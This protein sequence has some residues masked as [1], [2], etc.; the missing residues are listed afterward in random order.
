MIKLELS[1]RDVIL[2]VLTVAAIWAFIELWPV[3]LLVFVSFIFMIGLLPYVDALERSGIR[4]SLSVLIVIAG[5]LAIIL[6]AFS[7]MVPA[8]ID[9]VSAVRDN[10]PE[11]ARELE[12][13]FASFGINVELQERARNVN[14]EELISGRAA[15][16]Y[17]QRVLTTTL[18]IITIA[19]MT[20]YLLADT[21][22]LAR[23]IAQFIPGDRLPEAES[24]FLSISRVVGGYLRGQLI[25]S[26]A[27]AVFTF[28]LLQL[29]GVPNA[30]AFAVLAG[31][32]DVVPLVGAF[33][34]TIPPVAAALQESSTRALAVLIAMIA[35]QQF[36]DRILVPRVYG[37]TLNLPPI[38]VLI[39]VLAGA[40]LMGVTGVLL[41][42]PLTAA[43]RVAIDYTIEHRRL[44]LMAQLEEQPLAPDT[45]EEE[46]PEVEPK[47]SRK[48]AARRRLR[49]VR[50]AKPRAD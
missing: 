25:T 11:S 23:F 29:L 42:L 8:L 27:I 33:V 50:A 49:P 20:A 37:R 9:E 14:W 44:P 5:I 6:G 32:A 43:A 4:R 21:P 24:L 16:D 17:G 19:V 39:A 13:L 7:L 34:A 10:L 28:V 1:Y 15:V 22:R 48:T 35:Y 3:F 12:E 30:L 46:L 31:F 38:I 18:S 45:P 2:I 47:P 36:E 41:A 40:E 26:L